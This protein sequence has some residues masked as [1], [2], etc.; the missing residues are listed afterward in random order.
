MSW[1]RVTLPLAFFA[2]F[3]PVA[4][5]AGTSE[6]SLETVSCEVRGGGCLKALS[7]SHLLATFGGTVGT[8]SAPQWEHVY[9]DGRTILFRL[10]SEDVHVASCRPD[11]N[12]PCK[13]PGVASRA[14]L[15]GIGTFTTAT[16]TI[17]APAN[18]QVEVFDPDPCNGDE[19]DT[20]S[21]TVRRGLVAGQ[22][23]IVHSISGSLDCGNLTIDA[24]WA[25]S[26]Q[27]R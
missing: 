11:P 14:E 6:M 10:R 19:R 16:D 24:P 17:A 2:A 8:G 15:V 20:Y 23:E 1:H 27:P 18:F 13:P 5:S 25:R 3:V 26:R 4:G 21:I 9:Y 22:G 7:P 12:G